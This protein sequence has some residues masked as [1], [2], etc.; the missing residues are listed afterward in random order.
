MEAKKMKGGIIMSKKEVKQIELFEQLKRKEIKQ[1][2]VAKLLGLSVRQIKRKFRRYKLYGPKSLVHKGRGK[3]SNNKIDQKKINEAMDTIRV[4]YSDFAP[5]LAYEK[6]VEEHGFNHSLT[7]LRS[8]MVKEGVW[9]PKQRSKARVHQLRERRACFGE[10]VQLDGSPH[11][12][13]EDRGPRCNLNVTIDDATG[14]CVFMFSKTETTQDYFKLLEKYFTKHGLPAALYVDKHS[15][16]RVN[17]PTNLDLKKPNK[18]DE[19]EGLTQFG[20]AI[21]ELGIELI[22][23]QSPEAKGRVERVNRTLQNRLVKELRLKGISTIEEAN[24]F[25][26]QFIEKFNDKFCVQPRSSVNAHKE[27]SNSQDL[28]KILCAK[29][30][31]TLSRNL[32]F[33]YQNTIFQVKTKKSAYT[34]RKTTVSIFERYDGN[35]SLW[36]HKNKPLEY[37]TIKKLPNNRQTSSKQLNQKVDVILS[38]KKKNPWESDPASYEQDNLFYKPAGVV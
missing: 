14:R 2:R 6:L 10:L 17:T 27:L 25:L 31:R 29:E 38:R 26:P 8:E 37:T 23:A 13:F 22:F 7:T 20:R 16:F 9:K 36:D 12:W 24:K 4:S 32:T 5:T 35:I 11:T 18:N 19:F 30:K 1:A 21:K 28:T 34:L 15:I 3:V 33:Q